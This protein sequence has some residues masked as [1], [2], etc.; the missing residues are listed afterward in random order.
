MKR[1]LLL[2]V[3]PGSKAAVPNL[4]GPIH[5]QPTNSCSQRFRWA[6]AGF[7]LSLLIS[8]TCPLQAQE[9]ESVGDAARA[10]RAHRAAKA[11]QDAAP[12][13]Q[14]PLS[15][16][17]IVEWQI[18][19]MRAPDLLNEL[20]TRGITFVPDD[21]HLNALKDAR[22]APELLASLPTVPSHP[23][24]S[25]SG[26]IPQALIGAAQAFGG[27]D[28]SAARHVLETLIQQNQD[29]NLYAALGNLNLLS[30]DLSSAKTAFARSAQLDPGFAYPHVRLAQ[31]YY[32]LEQRSQVADEAKQALRL[33]PGNAE[34]HKYLA[35]AATMDM[36]DSGGGASG[37]AGN[38]VEDLSDLTA[39]SNTEAKDLNN[40]GVALAQQQEWAKAEAAYRRAI[41]LDPKVALYHYNL[42]NLYLKWRHPQQALAALNEAKALAPRNMAV[43]Q[44]LGYTLCEFNLF[45]DA[46]TELREMLSIDPHWN[47]ARPCLIK[48]LDGLGRKQEADQVEMDYKLYKSSDDSGD[49]GEDADDESAKTGVKL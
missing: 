16:I 5:A 39:G 2:S 48:A 31:V 8:T 26:E 38:K 4:G 49:D 44:N 23:D 47:M 33:Q 14:P 34:A 20:Q 17:T 37:S 11:N 22:V 6:L 25:G 9:T 13:A 36:P 7:C 24:V 42:G 21:A 15:A 12:V 43:R 27:K 41:E 32:R 10:F 30:G 45:S 46:V 28:Y 18:A 29:A 35:L 1:N 40:Q 19:G 3:T